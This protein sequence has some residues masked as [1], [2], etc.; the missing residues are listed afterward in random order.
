MVGLLPR[1]A[2]GLSLVLT[3]C[4][5]RSAVT[6]GGGGDGST[7]SAASDAGDET[8]GTGPNGESTSDGALDSSDDGSEST[9]STGELSACGDPWDLHD[10]LACGPEH[11]GLECPF[12][13]FCAYGYYACEEGSWRYHTTHGCGAEPVPCDER[14]EATMGCD[15]DDT[16]DLDGD[17]LDVL[18][19]EG[20]NWVARDVCNEIACPEANPGEGLPCGDEQ[21]WR[22]TIEI[23][24]GIEREFYC[25]GDGFW[26]DYTDGNQP[27]CEAPLDCDD[28]PLPGDACPFEMELCFF[29]DPDVDA[30]TCTDGVWG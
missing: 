5:D 24:C 11:V 7:G 29:D 15:G 19:C 27:V 2:L 23:A 10:G 12:G 20:S 9:D 16:C 17:C 4:V 8:S 28:G 21:G 30:L 6:M 1:G 22:C 3:A 25:T 14:T 13:D 18:E 26:R